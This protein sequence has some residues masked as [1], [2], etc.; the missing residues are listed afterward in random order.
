MPQNSQTTISTIA[1]AQS[2][3]NSS[4][5]IQA[6]SAIL[7]ALQSVNYAPTTANDPMARFVQ[8]IACVLAAEPLLV[9]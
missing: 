9:P 7:T 3:I 2:G 6:R 1:D 4:S 8:E 5:G